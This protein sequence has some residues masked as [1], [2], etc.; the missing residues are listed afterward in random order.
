M[1]LDTGGVPLI[2]RITRKSSVLLGLKPGMAVFAQ[3][4]SV[5]LLE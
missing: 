2:A 1:R 4:K 5:A 3:V